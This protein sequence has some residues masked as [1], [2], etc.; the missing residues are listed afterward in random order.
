MFGERVRSHGKESW[1]FKLDIIDLIVHPG[2][3]AE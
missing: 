3:G 1:G 2:R